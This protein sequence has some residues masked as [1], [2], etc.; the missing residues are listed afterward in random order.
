MRA[1]DFRA[2]LLAI[3]LASAGQAQDGTTAG[4]FRNPDP[5]APVEITADRLDLTRSEGT[6]LFTGDVLAIQGEMRLTAQSLLITYLLEPDGSIG[7]EI[8]TVEAE[9]NVLLVTPDEAAEGDVA[10]YSPRTNEVVMTGD[11]LLTQGGNT[12]AG[13]RLVVDLETGIGEVQGRVR[14]VIQPATAEQ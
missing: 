14:T 11:V 4:G 7:E 5:D 3:A 2:S 12:V 10:V 6:A 8:D 13:E 9:G 1:T